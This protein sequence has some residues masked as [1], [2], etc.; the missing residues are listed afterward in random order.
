MTQYAANVIDENM[1]SQVDS[2]GHADGILDVIADYYK[3]D[4]SVPIS[5][6]YV[7]TRSDIRRLCHTT[8]DWH[9]LVLWKDEFEKWVSLKLLK[10]HNPVEISEF[11]QSRG[12]SDEPY[13][14]WWVLY[15]LRKIDRIIAAV[16]ARV[17]HT[18]HKY[19]IEVPTSM[20]HAKRID[21][22]NGNRF[23]HDA[24]DKETT[25]AAVAFEIVDEGKPTPVGSIKARGHLVFDVKMDF[26][27]NARWVKDVPRTADPVHS[28]FSG[29]VSRD[30]LNS[31]VFFNG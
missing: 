8:E 5:E 4:T 13:L 28:I 16:N 29:V 25:N 2:D 19:G 14:C 24:I 27:R 22:Y 11:A 18:T 7:N 1:Y 3:D 23:C 15:T 26:N 20:D 6:K 31:V 9:L 17:H 12:I 21:A 10:E 30:V